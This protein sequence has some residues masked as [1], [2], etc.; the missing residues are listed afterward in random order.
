MG[1]VLVIATNNLSICA[2][3][4]YAQIF[5]YKHKEHNGKLAVQFNY[6]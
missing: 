5:E 6:Y 2:N 1:V 4:A 3:G